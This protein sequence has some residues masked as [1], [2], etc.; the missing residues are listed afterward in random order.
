M[1]M[2]LN[3]PNSAPTDPLA[4]AHRLIEQL[5]KD[6]NQAHDEIMLAQGWARKDAALD[7]PAWTPQANSIRWAETMLGKKLAK[8]DIWSVYPSAKPEP[9]YSPESEE[10]LLAKAR[11]ETKTYPDG[12]TAT[13]TPPLPDSSPA[14]GTSEPKP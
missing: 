11:I 14:E 4:D 10:A 13:G 1:S 5:C 8:T 12:V 6:L 3:P 9:F 7:W 2:N